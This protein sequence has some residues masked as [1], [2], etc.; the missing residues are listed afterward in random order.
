MVIVLGV[1]R[2][3][4]TTPLLEVD[5][6]RDMFLDG[7]R[8]E[9]VQGF[10]QP[11]QL[12]V[13]PDLPN[14]NPDRE[15]VAIVP[16]TRNCVLRW[17]VGAR[18]GRFSTRVSRLVQGKGGDASACR[19]VVSVVGAGS[20]G[21]VPRR[22]EV[23]VPG[24]SLDMHAADAPLREG[25]FV[26]VSLAL[27]EGAE[28][29]QFEVISEGDV[30]PGSF[31]ALLSPRVVHEPLLLDPVDHPLEFEQEQWLAAAWTVPASGDAQEA[32][33]GEPA[34]GEP[35]TQ[36]TLGSRRPLSGEQAGQD[37]PVEHPAIEVVG[38][39]TGRIGRHAMAF[40]GEA[41]FDTE[42]D[43]AAQSMLRGALAMDDRLPSDARGRLLVVVDDT[44][45]ARL[46]VSGVDWVDVAVPLG[47]YAGRGRRL[48]LRAEVVDVG[49]GAVQQQVANYVTGV[50]EPVEFVARTTRLGFA[51]PQLTTPVAVPRRLA[52]ADQP[53]VILIQVETLRADVLDP[54]GGL[55]PGLTPNL[56]R[57]ASRSVVYEHAIVP[58]SWT[59]PTTASLL[60][61][62][63]PS[64]H[65]VVA[66]LQRV[67]P[68][69][70]PTLAERAR[71]EGVVTAAFVT[72]TLLAEDAG[73]GRGFETYGFMP[74]KNA[75]QVNAQA[76]AFLKNHVGQQFLLFLHYFDPH[77]PV[78]AP[79]DWQD[80]FV[81]P[82]YLGWD[83]F[84]TELRLKQRYTSGELLGPQDPDVRFL[85]QRYLGEIAYFDDQLGQLLASID[86]LGLAPSTA[87]VLTADHGEEFLEHGLWGHGSNLHKETIHVP[88]MVTTAGALQG[89]A[90]AEP[91][92]VEAERVRE[93]VSTVGVHAEVLKLLQVPFEAD[94]LYYDLTPRRFA[95]TET[96]KGLALDGLGDPMRR[97]LRAVRSDTHMLLQ[98][99]PVEGEEG[100]GS[101]CLFDLVRDPHELDPLTPTGQEADLLRSFLEAANQ[102][103]LEHRVQA[104]GQGSDGDSFETLKALGY[105]GA[106]G[107][108]EDSCGG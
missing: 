59:A 93:V 30:P 52:S 41:Q 3:W 2:P 49:S 108:R 99:L 7:D 13:W 67:I 51:A 9:F 84:E 55:E 10:L 58:S 98:R 60:T 19:L 6:R 23:D 42:V 44:E 89:F 63:L 105:I 1:L 28:T 46:E 101:L 15:Q 32:E 35:E 48:S 24:V 92:G 81:Q 8:L 31:V 72:N 80:R 27:P 25:P 20:S 47:A 34:G 37:Q 100:S 69:A 18:P 90:S 79:G 57:L 36:V 17:H 38:S 97:P 74:F 11:P 62:V 86:R 66:N 87:I 33:Q 50:Y 71:A 12:Y 70:L 61:G 65:G 96:N 77:M 45:V 103:I 39:F 5:I 91:S 64:A 94:D 14:P 102:W 40:T 106:G 78:D 68:Y 95:P 16:F 56:D 29:L 73:Y 4:R 21:G 43:L 22:V 54:F 107:S 104:P 75:R 76:E 53:S 85:R 82:D 26:S 88:L 83:I